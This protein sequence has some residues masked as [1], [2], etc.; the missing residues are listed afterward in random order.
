MPLHYL[1]RRVLVRFRKEL[2]FPVN[3]VFDALRLDDVAIVGSE[4]QALLV[5]GTLSFASQSPIHLSGLPN[6]AFAVQLPDGQAVAQLFLPQMNIATGANLVRNATLRLSKLD[7]HKDLAASSASAATLLSKWLSSHEQ[8]LQVAGPEL[9]NHLNEEERGSFS[10]SSS[11]AAWRDYADPATLPFTLAPPKTKILRSAEISSRQVFF[12]QDQGGNLCTRLVGSHCMRGPLV[13]FENPF[14]VRAKLEDV[15]LDVFL[16]EDPGAYDVSLHSLKV[17]HRTFSCSST[18]RLMHLQSRQGM[19]AYLNASRSDDDTV[20]LPSALPDGP[21]QPA[22]PAIVT[23]LLINDLGT[24]EAEGC[25]G[26]PRAG[27]CS[28]SKLTAEACRA[29]SKEKMGASTDWRGT[30][31]LRVQNFNI[32]LNVS[33]EGVPVVFSTDVLNLRVGVATA[34][35]SDFFFAGSDFLK[36]N[37]TKPAPEVQASMLVL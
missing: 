22:S 8:Q 1:G 16:R 21:A 20:P 3:P 11:V 18:R 32:S 26:D 28:A 36:Q 30:I 13:T 31:T 14:P 29:V 27:C 23:A 6:I 9:P 19:W 10:S 2:H 24:A 25:F 35:C 37:S 12:G 33:W 7:M 5:A 4:E 17:M 15:N 34:R